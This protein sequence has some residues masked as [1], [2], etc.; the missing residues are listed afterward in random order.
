[1]LEGRGSGIALAWGQGRQF[2]GSDMLG[3]L[4]MGMLNAFLWHGAR[5]ALRYGM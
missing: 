1:M 2:Y 5:F 3:A 4:G